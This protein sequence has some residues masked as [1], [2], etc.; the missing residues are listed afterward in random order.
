MR[1]RAHKETLLFLTSTVLL[2]AGAV[3]HLW[4]APTPARVLWIAGTTLGSPQTDINKS[5]SSGFGVMLLERLV[6][7]YYER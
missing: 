6:A 5:W 1:L 2:L 3:A 7:D 4:S